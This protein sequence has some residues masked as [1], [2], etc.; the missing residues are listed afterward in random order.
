MDSHGTWVGR[1]TGTCH[2]M[3]SKRR[4]DNVS[5]SDILSCRVLGG[6][7]GFHLNHRAM[8]LCIIIKMMI[9]KKSLGS[10][11]G[12]GCTVPLQAGRRGG[13]MLFSKL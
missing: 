11:S 9:A 5:D 13:Q 6:S 3:S 12:E 7:Q 8:E 2:K 10:S 4:A 1:A